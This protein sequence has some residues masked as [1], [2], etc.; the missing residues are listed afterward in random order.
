MHMTIIVVEEVSTTFCVYT[1]YVV[2]A[3]MPL[4]GFRIV[5]LMQIY[6]KIL[7]NATRHKK[8]PA[9]FVRG[10]SRVSVA[11]FS[12]GPGRVWDFHARRSISSIP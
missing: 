10:F 2:C 5:L 11:G 6:E 8:S 7:I 9:F 1:R 12:A 4:S 3:F